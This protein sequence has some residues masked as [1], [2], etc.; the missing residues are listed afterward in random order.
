MLFLTCPWR[1]LISNELEQLEFKV[2]NLLGFRTMQER[3]EIDNLLLNF[4]QLI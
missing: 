2:E 4:G 3:L 1:F